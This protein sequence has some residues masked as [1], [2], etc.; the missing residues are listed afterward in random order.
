MPL[1][2]LRTPPLPQKPAR[3]GWGS[4]S[5]RVEQEPVI[6]GGPSGRASPTP[7]DPSCPQAHE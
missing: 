6:L 5:F 2:C 7:G 4:A 1:L 3:P